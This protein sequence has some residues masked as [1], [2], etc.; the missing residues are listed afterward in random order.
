LHEPSEVVVD[1]KKCRTNCEGDAYL[2]EESEG[3]QGL[4][5]EP[6]V[7]RCDALGKFYD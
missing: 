1:I 5:Q 7:D 3:V 6:E 4:S 2:G